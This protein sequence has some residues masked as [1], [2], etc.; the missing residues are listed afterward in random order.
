MTE[1]NN[2]VAVVKLNHTSVTADHVNPAGFFITKMSLT[3]PKKVYLS[4]RRSGS[5]TQ[6]RDGADLSHDGGGQRRGG[7]G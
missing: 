3:W 4:Q 1:V 6:G 2:A 7:G 5:L